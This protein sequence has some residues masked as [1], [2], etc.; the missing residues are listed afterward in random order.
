MTDGR[1][2]CS[3]PGRTKTSQAKVMSVAETMGRLHLESVTIKNQARFL[4][5][6]ERNSANMQ[7]ENGKSVSRTKSSLPLDARFEI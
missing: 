5:Y 3:K 2:L 1:G 7:L 6:E 4:V